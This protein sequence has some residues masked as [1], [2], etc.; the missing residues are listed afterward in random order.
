MSVWIHGGNVNIASFN[1][2]SGVYI[3]Q[4]ME[5]GWDSLSPVKIAAGFSMGDGNWMWAGYSGYWGWCGHHQGLFDMDLK[6]NG[7]PSWMR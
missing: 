2:N 5:D 4:N 7:T 1:N 6:N 3:G